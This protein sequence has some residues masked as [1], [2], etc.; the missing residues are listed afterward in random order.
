MNVTVLGGE[1]ARH[2]QVFTTEQ[3]TCLVGL[4][5]A[6]DSWRILKFVQSQEYGIRPSISQA[7]GSGSRRLYDLENVCEFALALRLLETGLRSAAIGK[8]IRQLKGQLS[9]KLEIEENEAKSVY[10]AIIRTPRT[11]ELL[12]DPRSQEVQFIEGI[13]EANRILKSHRSED[14]ILVPVGSLFLKLERR[15]RNLAGQG[16]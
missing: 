2:P 11:G 7:S 9:A 4:N 13:E 1:M 10:L 3:V 16:D 6:E 15:L 14:V 12:D 5:P 8:V